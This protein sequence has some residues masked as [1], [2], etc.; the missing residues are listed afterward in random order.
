ML[1]YNWDF[2]GPTLYINLHCFWTQFLSSRPIIRLS[3]RA[4]YISIYCTKAYTPFD[5]QETLE[6]ACLLVY[7]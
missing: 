5:C 3:Y 7:I 4:K 1:I 6:I 2:K